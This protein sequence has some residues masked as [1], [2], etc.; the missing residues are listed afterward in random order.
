MHS[1]INNNTLNYSAMPSLNFNIMKKIL[2]LS[3]ATFCFANVYSQGCSDAGFCSLSVLKNNTQS[4]KLKNA[5]S[6][7][8]N[9]GSGEQNTS[10]LNPYIEYSTQVSKNVTFQTKLTSTYA[11]GFLGSKFNLGDAFAFITWKSNNTKSNSQFTFIHGFKI[12]LTS[13][14]DKNSNGKPLPLDYQSSLGTF[15]F[16]S[17]V[18]LIVNKKWEFNTGFQIPISNSNKNSFF[19]SD[20]TDTRAQKFIPTNLFERKPDVLL[21][22]G[23]YAQKPNS[24]FSIKPN[25]LAIYHIGNDSYLNKTGTR[26]S[27]DGSQGLTLNANIVATKT[28]KNET[29]LELVAATPVVVRTA[30]P[31]GLTRSAVLNIQYKIPF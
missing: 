26:V 31:D 14:N 5:I 19:P 1:V 17:G 28:F 12:P 22:V 10:T 30:R 25:L 21:R 11:N 3:A 13:A 4:S 24:S 9:Y 6:I 8:L 23:Y 20:Y 7:G 16:I 2:F 15:D 29:Q 18:N 27:I